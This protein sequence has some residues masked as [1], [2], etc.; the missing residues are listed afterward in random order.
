MVYTPAHFAVEDRDI[1]FDHIER[2]GLALLISAGP[3]GPIA[4]H[5]PM[6]LERDAGANGR[7]VGHLAKANPHWR[8]A[9]ADQPAL[10]VFQGPDA[11]I[12]PSWYPSKQEHGRVVPTWN[13]AVVH[14]RGPLAFF[15]DRDRLH[16]VV[17]RLTDFHEARR[18][19]PWAVADAPERFVEAQLRG[20]VGFTLEIETLIGKYK[21]SQNRP[22]ED[23]DGVVAG[24]AGESDPGARD[25]GDLVK[26]AGTAAASRKTGDA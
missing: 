4:S 2:T 12:T 17:T 23:R 21:M 13:Y 1:L 24:L 3:D 16:D 11:Y 6:L 14:A 18:A 19:A 20:I 8:E 15:E 5:A 10:A 7:L 22:Q 9:R 26:A 25:T